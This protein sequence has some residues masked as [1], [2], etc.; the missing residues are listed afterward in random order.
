MMVLVSAVCCC[1]CCCCCSCTAVDQGGLGQL[2]EDLVE[3]SSSS[4]F[5]DFQI[6][7]SKLLVIPTP[8]SNLGS[9]NN[10]GQTFH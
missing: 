3:A 8:L 7:G 6:S 2:R 1:C 9:Q 10:L 5:S 4:K